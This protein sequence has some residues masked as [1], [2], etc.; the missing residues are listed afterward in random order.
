MKNPWTNYRSLP[1]QTKSS[2][3]YSASSF[4]QKCVAFMTIP[5]FSRILSSY[6]Y[7]KYA[8]F[9]SWYEIMLILGTWR[10]YANSY[11]VGL[12]KFENDKDRYTSSLVGFGGV[13][14]LFFFILVCL[15][16]RQF[17][18]WTEL[19]FTYTILLFSEILWMPALNLWMQYNRYHFYY[20]APNIV[21]LGSALLM[22]L[23]GIP[24]IRH[25]S[26][27]ALGAILAKSLP[28]ILAGILCAFLVLRKNRTL[29]DKSYWKY[30]VC[31]N[32]PLLFYYI[33]RT[34]L[35]QI[36]RIMIQK[37]GT[38]QQVGIYSI[39]NSAAHSLEF[40]SAAINISLIPHMFQKLR[41]N[42]GQDISQLTGILILCVGTFN[43]LLILIAP[44][45]IS[46]LA[47]EDYQSAKWLV[48]PLSCSIVLAF[49]Y[50]LYCNME[51]YHE[52]KYVLMLSSIG[53]CIA[54]G[55][56]DYIFISLFGFIAAGYTTLFCNLLFLIV[57]MACVNK[58]LG[59]DDSG[60]L[61]D[62]R[63]ILLSCAGI[64]VL[65]ALV[66]LLYN[67][68]FLRYFLVLLS[69]ILLFKTGRRFFLRQ[70]T[71]Q[72]H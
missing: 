39:A 49:I 2:L 14:T 61:P 26:D 15:F 62:N 58:I 19:P 24:L 69:G 56:L 3:W 12:G 40:I 17:E 48:P 60:T 44:E 66:M 27:H 32:A 59:T 9:N 8:V 37:L 35:T 20:K 25:L 11:Y 7:G 22:P 52:K 33:A 45:L 41:K 34:F 51:F 54:N 38:M 43:L 63:I 21:A 57:H 5:V 65:S 71:T 31:F 6:E 64:I 72:N 55:F 53:M 36:D 16:Q 10:I 18:K 46:F 1:A 70:R 67:I 68:P 4:L 50:Q 47:P 23:I 13:C 28:Q 30:T 42:E 29:Y